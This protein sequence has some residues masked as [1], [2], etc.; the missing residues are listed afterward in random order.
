MT[1][2]PNGDPDGPADGYP[3]SIF[4][5]GHDAIQYISEVNIPVP[6]ISADRD[7]EELN[8]AGTVQDF[9]DVR[10][11]LYND[12]FY[13]LEMP[14]V[15]LAYLPRQGSQTTDKL[16]FGWA[17]HA[18]EGDAG[19]THGW[20]ELN[21]SNPRS[22]GIWQIGGYWNYVTTD[23]IFDIPQ[24]WADTYT[25]DK[26]LVAGRFREGGQ[27]GEGPSLFAYGPWN[28]GNP[29]AQGSTLSATPLLLYGNVY[30]EN[31]IAIN[32][33]Q[34]C[35]EWAGGAWLTAGDKAAVIFV[36]TKGQGD[37]WYGFA[38]GTV[39]PEEPPYPPEPPDGDRGFWATRFVG[40]ILF[41]SPDDLAAVAQ[42]KM[43]T[44]EPQPYA[45]MDID[46]FLYHIESEGQLHHVGAASF[47]RERGLL[48]IF[49]P[50][51]DGGKP[52]IHA[53]RVD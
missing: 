7:V 47:D 1:Y 32:N 3:G 13:D 40:Q 25:P 18:Q 52:L 43:E 6:V 11:N 46:Q 30:E 9:H 29:P 12:R 19:P 4:G 39:W 53:W 20:C 28:E 51:A 49:E 10:G 48:Y 41:Y 42:G 15:G 27:G 24:S 22:A 14:R 45:T 34:H 16:Y 8:T 5:A 26:Y 33:Y 38:D 37:C 50:L 31:P 36:G 21:L 17:I 44:W 23:Y 2:Y 35:D